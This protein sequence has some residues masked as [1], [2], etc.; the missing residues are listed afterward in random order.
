MTFRFHY[1]CSSPVERAVFA[2]QI[3]DE[4]N[5]LV[6]GR[7]SALEYEIPLKIGEGHIDFDIPDLVLNS[8]IYR[9]STSITDQGKIFDA[10]DQSYEFRVRS[11]DQTVEGVFALPGV[12]GHSH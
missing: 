9:V 1:R 11:T 2:F 3:F 10:R 4:S 8:G 7:S 5:R 6:A 12:W